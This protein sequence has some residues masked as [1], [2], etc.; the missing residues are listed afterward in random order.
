MFQRNCKAKRI[1]LTALLLVPS[2]ASSCPDGY[3]NTSLGI[4][5]PNSGTVLKPLDQVV[6]ETNAVLLEQWITNSRNDAIGNS[7]SIPSEIHQRLAGTF[8]EDVFSRVRFKIGDN[9]FF[10]AGNNIL[11]NHDVNAVTL[12]DVIIFRGTLQ[13]QDAATW[14]HE[15]KHIQQYRD[16]GTH[17]F[18]VHYLR[19]YTE[20]E[21]PAYA[22]QHQVEAQLRTA[23]GLPPGSTIQ[24]C[25][26]QQQP[27]V[28]VLPDARCQSGE[29][30]PTSC[31]STCGP[32]PVI[33]W[34]CR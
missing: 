19:D 16:W 34:V 17:S 4:C 15:L 31:P 22:V 9:G 32:F 7:A 33:A 29:I 20:V 6:A 25:G 30:Q 14:A 2:I 24:P 27:T 11:M 18:A 26:C 13:A 1:L 21:N 12:I 10:N 3:Y 8:D 5:L 28:L 23:S